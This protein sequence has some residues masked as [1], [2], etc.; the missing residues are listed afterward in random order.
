MV[1]RADRD[2]PARRCGL[3]DATELSPDARDAPSGA[4]SYQLHGADMEI[5]IWKPFRQGRVRDVV[6]RVAGVV[7]RELEYRSTVLT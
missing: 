3:G 4:V 6:E 1:P 7:R 5:G 2:S